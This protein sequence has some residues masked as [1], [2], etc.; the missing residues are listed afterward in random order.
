MDMGSPVTML[1]DGEHVGP[2]DTRHR[3]FAIVRQ[4]GGVVRLL[5]LLVLRHLFR[6]IV[7]SE[8]QPED[9]VVEHRR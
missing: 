8:R 3:I 6:L 1:R 4:S 7:F 2:H 9:A 5:Y